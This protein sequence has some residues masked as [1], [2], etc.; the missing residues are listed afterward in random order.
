MLFVSI[1]TMSSFYLDMAKVGLEVAAKRTVAAKEHLDE[2]KV[3]VKD[4][5]NRTDNDEVWTNNHLYDI[6]SYIVINDTACVWVFHDQQE[7]RL[8]NI[9][10]GSYENN[11]QYAPDNVRH[12]SKQ[13]NVSPD[14][15][16]LVKPYVIEFVG[17]EVDE[18]PEPGSFI[19][20][21]AEEGGIIK[22]PPRSATA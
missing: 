16:I 8:V 21:S 22:P 3:P 12:I 11:D 19:I 20:S 2:I 14:G 17:T 9:I 6:S 18:F 4:F 13:H 7:E 1:G 10:I 5:I 15:K